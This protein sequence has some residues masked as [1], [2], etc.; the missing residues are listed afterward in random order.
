MFTRVAAATALLAAPLA[1]VAGGAS[2]AA[3]D[4]N[5]VNPIT[6]TASSI[7]VPVNTVV[8]LRAEQSFWDDITFMMA[9]G[10]DT[11]EPVYGCSSFL[12]QCSTGVS[13]AFATRRTY[14]AE[15]G[16]QRSNPVVVTWYNPSGAYPSSTCSTPFTDTTVGVANV[17]ASTNSSSTAVDLCVRVSSVVGSTGGKLAITLP[18]GPGVV[19]NLPAPYT[20]STPA[21]AC[22]TAP[23]NVNPIH[24]LFSTTTAGQTVR[25]DAYASATQAWVCVRTN[26][27]DLRIV[28][29]IHAPSGSVL[30]G[31]SANFYPDA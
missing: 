28:Q 5:V 13:F 4:H 11:S 18:S 3:G 31:F 8:T 16:N 10:L 17:R 25:I 29:P 1:V 12:L 24:P 21:E 9:T 14:Y 26:S 15:N 7:F 27:G 22:A 20:D 23:G 2:P 19:G 30:P 6:L